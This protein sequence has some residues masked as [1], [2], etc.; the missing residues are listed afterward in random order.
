MSRA[1]LLLLVVSL[2]C[3]ALCTAF[4]LDDRQR[5]LCMTAYKV[6]PRKIMSLE[7]HRSS[8]SC[9][10]DEI[11][12]TLRNRKKVCLHPNTKLWQFLMQQVKGSV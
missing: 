12:V 5:C 9:S 10:K 11:V 8:A 2:A 3:A 7:V 6:M 1:I 4:R